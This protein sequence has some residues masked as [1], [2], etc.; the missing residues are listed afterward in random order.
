MKS[1]RLS[2]LTQAEVNNLKA[3]PRINF[4]SIFNLVNP[5]VDDVHC[6]GDAAVKDYTA[7]FDK[8]ELDKTVE[9]VGELPHPQVF[10]P[11]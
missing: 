8:V 2:E 6:R 3:R 10:A 5:I 1:Y 9:I 7:K 4:S 11:L